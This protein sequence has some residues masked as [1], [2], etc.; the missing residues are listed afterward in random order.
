MR[1]FFYD[2]GMHGVD[3]AAMRVKY[4]PLAKAANHRQDVNYVIGELIGE[5]NVG[6][7]YVNGGDL[8][9]VEKIKMGLLG[10][11]LTRDASGY[12]KIDR[13]LRGK[14]W[15]DRDRSPL[16]DVG[17]DANEG[18]YI[19][20]INGKSVKDC[21]SIYEMLINTA[22]QTIEIKVNSSPSA[23][24][25]R[26][27]LVV[28]IADESRLYYLDWVQKNI[29][30]VH[31]KTNGQVAYLHIPDMG[32]NGL[33]E[34]VKHY[35]PQLDKKAIIIDDRGNGGGNVSPQII[36]RLNRKVVFYDMARNVTALTTDPGGMINGPKVA[37]IDQ[38]SASDGDIFP[39]RFKK[40]GMGK[41]IGR[42]SWGGIVGIRGSLPFIDGG[43]LRKPEF[44]G[45]TSDGKEWPVEG[46]GVDPDIVVYNNPA[47][48]FKGKDAQLDK[49]IEVILEEL[50][51]R[52]EDPK[53][54]PFPVKTK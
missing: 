54:P 6:H 23:S 50:K 25:G 36:E 19:I 18:D 49:A 10:A 12:Y 8:P 28:P 46:V 7:A 35:Y 37:L 24:G 45:F 1:D 13:I 4:E 3:W 16:S 5:L 22:G 9:D 48:E 20:E 32:V 21:I 33:N 52:P 14:N 17:V 41:V 43:D 15:S 34:F 53:M 40:Y 44:T 27:S 42:R 26:K 51:K 31:E 11:Q 39:Y 29:D 38:Y 2:P 30:Y 47:D